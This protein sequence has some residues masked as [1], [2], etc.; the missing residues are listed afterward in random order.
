MRRYVIPAGIV[1]LLSLSFSWFWLSGSNATAEH[2]G[3]GGFQ[4]EGAWFTVKIPQG[5]EV[6]PSRTSS[7]DKEALSIWVRSEDG[8]TEF[9]LY[10]PQWGGTPYDIFLGALAKRELTQRD[11]PTDNFTDLELTYKDAIGRFE[12]SQSSDPVSHRTVGY[13]TK[14]GELSQETLQ[15][16]DCFKN[17]IN[18]YSD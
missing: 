4:Y 3:C 9:Y 17:S 10:S 11:T 5:M 2:D 16:Y 15:K 14:T 12:I 1:L 6:E 8:R 13:R 18:Q 7:I